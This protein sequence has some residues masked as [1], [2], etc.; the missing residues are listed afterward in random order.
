MNSGPMA[1]RVFGGACRSSFLLWLRAFF[2]SLGAPHGHLA[3]LDLLHGAAALRACVVILGRLVALTGV[4]VAL[5]DQEPILAATVRFAGLHADQH[6][7]AFEPIAMQPEFEIALGQA[8]VGVAD[9]LPSALV[10]DHH[11]AAAI[12]AFGDDAFEAAIFE[13]VVLGHDGEPLLC[14]VEARALGHGPALQH[15]VMLEPE[16]E[17]GAPR[18]VLLD[19]EAVA[20]CGCALVP[21]SGVL[22]KSRLARY[23]ESGSSALVRAMA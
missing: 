10:P 7:I 20:A 11:R 18:R 9:R 8:F 14:R 4:F 23:V 21:G 13:R 19:D 15:A 3:C 2:F 12:F 1:R 5:L 6:P 17:M 22:L 16:I